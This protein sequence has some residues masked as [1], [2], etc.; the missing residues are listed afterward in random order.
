MVGG[1]SV[2]VASSISVSCC[3][4]SGSFSE[5]DRMKGSSRVLDA[6]ILDHVMAKAG[7]L[8]RVF[9]CISDGSGG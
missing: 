5:S 8:V 7:S 6:K 4:T 2:T 3:E 9:L 1:W